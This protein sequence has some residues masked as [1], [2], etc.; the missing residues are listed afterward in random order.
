MCFR[1]PDAKPFVAYLPQGLLTF[2]EMCIVLVCRRV[3]DLQSCSFIFL[4]AHSATSPCLFMHVGENNTCGYLASVVF[5][6]RLQQ[7]G[8]SLCVEHSESMLMRTQTCNA[9]A[10]SI[11][12]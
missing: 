12:Q 1:E 3:F 9:H 6:K 4:D 8:S 10:I 7:A 2:G 5:I 11:T